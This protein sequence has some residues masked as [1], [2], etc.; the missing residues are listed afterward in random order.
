M[1]HLWKATST[2]CDE[3]CGGAVWWRVGE[4]CNMM[5]PAP[6]EG[7]EHVEVGVEDD[8]DAGQAF[9]GV[10]AWDEDEEDDDS[11]DEHKGDDPAVDAPCLHLGQVRVVH[12]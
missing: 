12:T 5:T 7:Y 1:P 3:G 4:M 8:H 10:P 11:R 9:A 6:V 2:W